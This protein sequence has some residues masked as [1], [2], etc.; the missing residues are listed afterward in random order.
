MKEKAENLLGIKQK[1]KLTIFV[2]SKE[3]KLKL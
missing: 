3:Q 2:Q 1:N